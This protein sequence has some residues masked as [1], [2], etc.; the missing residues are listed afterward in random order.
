[1]K[2]VGTQAPREKGQTH[3]GTYQRHSQEGKWE[4]ANLWESGSSHF[5]AST[6]CK[7]L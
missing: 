1:M 6:V 3:W 4:K 7:P 2:R 5:I